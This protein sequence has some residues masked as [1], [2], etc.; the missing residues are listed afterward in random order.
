[1]NGTHRVKV[2]VPVRQKSRFDVL[3]EKS[4]GISVKKE[5]REDWL[6]CTKLLGPW[7]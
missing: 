2:H 1:M 4:G 6:G 5:S 3:I 7:Q